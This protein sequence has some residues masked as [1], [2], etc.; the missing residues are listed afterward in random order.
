MA[1]ENEIKVQGDGHIILQDVNN[2]SISINTSDSKDII[3]K[4]NQ[5]ERVHLDALAQ[6][7]DKEKENWGKLFDRLLNGFLSEKNI[8]KG[9]I[10]NVKDAI[11]GDNNTKNYYY[12]DKKQKPKELSLQ[13]PTLRANQIVGREKDLKDLH[14]RLFDKK[15]VV[16]VNGM[17]GIGKTTL[18]QVYL[19]SYYNKYK[20]ILWIGLNTEEA[21]FEADFIRTEGLLARFDI[22]PV[23]K[24]IRQSFTALI[25][26]LKELNGSP[27]LLVLDNATA[28]L[29]KH[30]NDLPNPP[31]WHI[32][33]TSRER[34]DYFDLK[35]LDFLSEAEA[36]QLF[37]EHYKHKK[38]SDAFLMDLVSDLEYH[39][40]TIE[41]L[42]KTAQE[43][44]TAPE[45]LLNAIK[46]D[47][48]VDVS[49]I[50]HSGEKILKLTTYLCR[51]FKTSQLNDNETWLLQ[52]FVCLPT[53]AHSYDL[54]EELI[55]VEE[56]IKFS[57]AKTLDRLS[58]KGWLLYNEEGDSYKIHRIIIDVV[59]A[60]IGLDEKEVGL[61]LHN[62]TT[63]LLTKNNPIDTFKWAPFGK[64]IL[65]QFKTSSSK[66]INQLQNNLA[67]VLQVLGDYKGAKVLLEKAIQSTEKN[68]GEDHPATVTTY[69]NLAI[70]LKDLGDYEGAKVLLEKAIESTEKNLGKD[71]P[72][73]VTTYSN[74]AV[75]LKDLG[76]YEAAKVL[77]EKAIQSTEKNLGKDHP[78]TATGYSN[79]A[80]VLKALGDYE[81]AKVLLEKVI[82]STEKNFGKNHPTTAISYSNL[83]IILK[84]FEDYEAAKVLL[85]KAKKSAEKN[86]GEDHPTTAIRYSN[87]ATVLKALGDYEAA[88]VLLEK[89]YGILKKQLGDDH[90]YTERGK[91]N[92]DYLISLMN[93]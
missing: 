8:I 47:L 82:Q 27:C 81:G 52:Q 35:E 71:H 45:I 78:A 39:T 37:R 72:T 49:G 64:A 31:N 30:Y 26:A 62:I 2:S 32:L 25:S 67:T 21:D 42:A 79:L 86:F 17:G 74:L 76:D 11:I 68:F 88:K 10:S 50:R 91:R 57:L 23:G 92:L 20:H 51:I 33:A 15:Q 54:L 46:S 43:Q 41:I 69:S 48:E 58:K 36:I 24:T 19:T 75:V 80:L 7:A 73:T 93:K 77:L 53:E 90:P 65:L 55:H 60:S 34:I 84:D 6:I 5:L 18:A 22:N 61:L 56:N 85:E 29:A 28:T 66:E 70:V 16:L 3:S 13:L 12:N 44:R 87:L 14:D 63:K 9:N 4:L 1:A 83:G 40:L 89:T 38:L 59:K